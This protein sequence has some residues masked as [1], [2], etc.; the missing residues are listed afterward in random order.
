MNTSFRFINFL[1]EFNIYVAL[2]TF[3]RSSANT[4]EFTE[5]GW[6]FK[7][8]VLKSLPTKLRKKAESFTPQ[9]I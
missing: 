2:I 4:L 8:I 6:L 1:L 9:A 7:R 3:F 5:N